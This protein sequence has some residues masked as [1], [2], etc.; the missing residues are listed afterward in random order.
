MTRNREHDDR[1]F[2]LPA[3]IAAITLMAIA[4][5]LTGR[6]V[7][8]LLRASM[9]ESFAVEEHAATNTVTGIIDAWMADPQV[10][11][12]LVSD[13][14]DPRVADVWWTPLGEQC[15]WGEDATCWKIKPCVWGEDATCWKIDT[16]TKVT[17]I[18]KLRGGEAERHAQDVTATVVV[19]CWGSTPDQC[20]RTRHIHP[21]LRTGRVLSVPAPLRH[22]RRAIHRLGRP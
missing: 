7:G 12:L 20:Q 22:Q 10:S 8:V 5:L 4:A 18:G 2:I 19:G 14:S 6:V 1:G 3:T 17:Y 15:V 13:P 9:Q 16:T 21:P 11:T